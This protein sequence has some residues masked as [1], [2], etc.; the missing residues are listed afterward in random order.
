MSK[1]LLKNGRIIDPETKRDE[2]AD[3]LIENDK[4]AKIGQIEAEDG[5]NVNDMTGKLIIPGL[6]DMHVHLRDMEQSDKETIETGTKA[7]RKGGVTTVFCMPNTVPELDSV[8][9]INK[10]LELIK[11]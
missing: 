1:I 2:T 6:V 7:A 8:E 3:I 4:I 10:Y 9:A 11:N 5:M